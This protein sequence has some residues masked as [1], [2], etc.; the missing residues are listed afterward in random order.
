M[1]I[2]YSNLYLVYV[3]PIGKNTTDYYEY[4]FIF[5]ETPDVV[6]G[7]NWENDTPAY[8][9]YTKPD[10]STY[11]HIERLKTQI[12]FNV[13]QEN[14]CYSMKDG[15]NKIIAIAWEN[16]NDYDEYP[17]EGRLVFHFGDKY[18]FVSDKLG[19]RHQLFSE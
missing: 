15:I 13:I 3:E 14:T 6:W 12:P 9:N 7:P 19:M 5:S 10:K 16:I 4:D 8:C 17:E 18:N 1:L 11:T 2:N